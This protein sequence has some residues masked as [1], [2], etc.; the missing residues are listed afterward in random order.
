MFKY[1]NTVILSVF[2]M[3]FTALCCSGIYTAVD[4]V[5]IEDIKGNMDIIVNEADKLINDYY[6][7]L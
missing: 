7:S 2:L 4:A 3:V 6:L 1:I 5:S